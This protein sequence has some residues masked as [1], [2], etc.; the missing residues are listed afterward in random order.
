MEEAV[1]A[2]R[3]AVDL[4]PE[5]AEIRMNLGVAL[6]TVGESEQAAEQF[7]EV[8]ARSAPEAG[9]NGQ[10]LPS[11]AE[12][13]HQLALALQG[14]DLDAAAAAYERALAINPEKLESYYG[15]GQALKRSSA[16]ARRSAA[17]AVPAENRHSASKRR[18]M[19]WR[20]AMPKPRSLN[21]ELSL[22]PSRTLPR[23][24]SC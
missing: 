8:L 22:N 23:P 10:Q 6:R 1:A 3:K 9:P 4:R 20:A 11:L 24:A 2:F 21:C 7:R 12:V 19:P 14:H 17:P 15:L 18:A 13:H 5:D 16:R